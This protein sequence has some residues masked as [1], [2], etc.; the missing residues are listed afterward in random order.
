MKKIPNFT[1]GNRRGFTLIELLTVISIIGILAGLLLPTLAQAKIKAKI[2]MTKTEMNNIA[3]A[4]TAY[5]GAYSR[6][7]CS[8]Y[9]SDSVA[10]LAAPDACPDFTFGTVDANNNVLSSAKRVPLPTIRNTGN[11]GGSRPNYQAYNAEVVSILRDDTTSA[12]GATVNPNHAKNPDKQNF[13]NV[14]DVSIP[15]QPGVNTDGVLRDL[16]GNPYIITLDLNY[17]DK[18]RDA[19]YRQESISAVSATAIQGLNGLSRPRLGIVNAFE[20][21]GGVMVWSF[22]PD[23][24]ANPAIPANQGQN[25]DNI[26]GWK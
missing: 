15:F 16:F 11:T 5:Y 9:A 21:R 23:A 13:L 4:I 2:T 1:R 10:N 22:G 20:A 7:P 19:F 3:G 8:T 26:L 12:V 6:Y 24:T 25:K 14:K 18:C 17:D